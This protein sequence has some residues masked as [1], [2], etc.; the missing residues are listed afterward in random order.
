MELRKVEKVTTACSDTLLWRLSGKRKE[1]NGKQ[2]N[3]EVLPRH[4]SKDASQ[5]YCHESN[6]VVQQTVT[7]W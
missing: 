7:E 3:L 6:L 4:R 2:L 5:A 1:N